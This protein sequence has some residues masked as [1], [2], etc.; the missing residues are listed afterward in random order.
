MGLDQLLE[1]TSN[2]AVK[3][4]PIAGVVVLIFLAIF[5]KRLVSLLNTTQDCV[6]SIKKTVET[7]NKELET[8]E[9]PLQTLNELSDTVDCVHE[10]SKHAVRSSIAIFLENLTYIKDWIFK[11]MGNEEEIKEESCEVNVDG[12]NG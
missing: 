3:A 2:V 1:L 9:K 10:A 8:L 6:Q 11:K 5:L 4:L 12:K 7:A